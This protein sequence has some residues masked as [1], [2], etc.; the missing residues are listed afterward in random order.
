MPPG[1]L[2]EFEDFAVAASSSKAPIKVVLSSGTSMNAG[3]TFTSLSPVRGLKGAGYRIA[4]IKATGTGSGN[5]LWIVARCG[6]QCGSRFHR[7][8]ARQHLSDVFGRY[9]C[10]YQAV[11]SAAPRSRDAKSAVVEIADGLQHVETLEVIQAKDLLCL[12]VGVV[13]AAYD[14]MGAKCGVDT[15]RAAGTRTGCELAE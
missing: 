3:K 13:F 15:L 12:F 1:V 10:C 14:L 7:W 6:R 2:F 9:R 11:L 8:W 5:D 4:A